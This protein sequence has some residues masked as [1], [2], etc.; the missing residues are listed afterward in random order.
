MAKSSFSKVSQVSQTLV[1]Q[2]TEYSDDT[3]LFI[4]IYQSLNKD[5][6]ATLT[7]L[8]HAQIQF[9]DPLHQL[10]GIDNFKQYLAHLYKNILNIHFDIKEVIEQNQQSCVF[11]TMSFTSK[12]LNKTEPIL[13]NG[14]SLL[15]YQYA[16]QGKDKN[17]VNTE[18]KIIYHRDYYDLGE[19]IYEYIPVLGHGIKFIKHQLRKS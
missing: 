18:N 2:D 5:N 4:N 15:K 6:L 1:S 17:Q 7:Q 14:M 16:L 3:C 10:N 9:I 19:M 8:Y 13:V 12:K 11:W